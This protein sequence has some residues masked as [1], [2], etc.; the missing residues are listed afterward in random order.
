MHLLRS[1]LLAEGKTL[2]E[3]TAVISDK[4]GVIA[5]LL[6]QADRVLIGGGMSY[7]FL[8]AQGHEMG[9]SLLEAD[10]VDQVRQIA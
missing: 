10:K 2:S 7:T 5:N 6:G 4:L 3:A 8:T 1:R 9:K